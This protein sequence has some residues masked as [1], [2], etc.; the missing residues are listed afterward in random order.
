MCPPV[1]LS[2]QPWEACRFKKRQ[3]AAAGG[4]TAFRRLLTEFTLAR[5][6]TAEQGEKL[7]NEAVA[8]AVAAS[9]RRSS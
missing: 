9:R 5:Q 6:R 3:N 7:L 4:S 1:V 2:Q 8:S